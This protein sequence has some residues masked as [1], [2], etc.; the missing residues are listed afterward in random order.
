VIIIGS[1]IGGLTT[2]AYLSKLG[3]KSLLLEQNDTLGGR[4]ANRNIGGQKFEIGAIYLGGGVF[5]HLRNIFGVDCKT[6]P[7]RCGV[8]IGN[9]IASFPID[10]RAVLELKLCGISWLE[11]FR[12]RYRMRILSNPELLSRYCSIGEVYDALTDNKILRQFFS[13]IT[14]VSGVSPYSLPS[15]YLSTQHPIARYKA[16]NPE[17]LQGGNGEIA[18]I[19]VKLAEKNC[20]IIR[21]VKIDKIIIEANMVKGVKSNQ[22]EYLGK[23]VVSNAGLRSTVLTLTDSGNWPKDYYNHVQSTKETLQVVNIFLTFSHTFSIP[24]D[25][26]VFFLPYNID[27]E[28]KILENGS[29]PEDSMFILHVPSNAEPQN[30][31]D[32]RATLQFYYPRE[33]RVDQECLDK[34]INKIMN[35]GLEKLFKGFSKA[36]TG[37]EVYDP[38]RY[39]K[40]FGLIPFV[41]GVSP[42]IDTTC[43]PIQTPI[44]GLF[45]TGDSVAPEGPCVPQAMESGLMCG[46]MVADS[47]HLSGKG[48]LSY[49]KN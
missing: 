22:Q 17:Y 40:E 27:E 25:Y 32:Y 15:R 26:T 11:L 13:V 36:I 12:L 19:L 41:F 8:R 33:I 45:C 16:L 29:F 9:G 48:L 39:E 38:S 49:L 18:S 37:Y 47:L 6:I 7:I 46:R 42:G 44:K 24:K 23:I 30:E 28:F 4:C 43:F 1:G 3:I 2:A 21:N 35:D 5:D 14:G 10:R 20:K 31:G 34:Q